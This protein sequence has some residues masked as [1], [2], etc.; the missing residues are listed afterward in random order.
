MYVDDQARLRQCTVDRPPNVRVGIGGA[1]LVEIRR[2]WCWHTSSMPD[3]PSPCS[4]ALEADALLSPIQVGHLEQ[5]KRVVTHPL[6]T[7]PVP[8]ASQA[9]LAPE[10]PVRAGSRTPHGA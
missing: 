9:G 7:A 10:A 5:V 8:T 6:T 3:S 1:I 2:R 4:V